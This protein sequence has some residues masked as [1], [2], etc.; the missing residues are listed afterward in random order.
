MG[1]AQDPLERLPELRVEDGVDDGVQRRVEVPQ[2]Q[3]KVHHERANVARITER[4]DQRQDEERQ[5]AHDERP[6]Y[7]GQRF[8][9][10]PFPLC[11]QRLLLVLPRRN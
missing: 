4:H 8:G 1:A 7:D 11:L 2:P 9:R 6:C 5:P 10:L 3:R